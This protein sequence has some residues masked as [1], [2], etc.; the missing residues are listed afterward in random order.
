M[1]LTQ[2]NLEGLIPDQHIRSAVPNLGYAMSL[3]KVRENNT[4]NGRIHE[5]GL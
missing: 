1:L 2:Q 5:N 3:L 4:D